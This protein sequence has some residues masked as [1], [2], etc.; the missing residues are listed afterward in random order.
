MRF[1]RGYE[2]AV[3][4]NFLIVADL[5]LGFELELERKGIYVPHADLLFKKLRFLI[6]I[7]KPNGLII[8]GD[9]KHM[10][11]MPLEREIKIVR[12]F[13]RKLTELVPRVVIVKGNHDGKIEE[14]CREIKNLEIVEELRF[15]GITLLHGHKK[16]ERFTTLLMGHV[17]PLVFSF[18][19]YEKA[20]IIA[21]SGK[22][23]IVVI[24]A[25][26]DLVGSPVSMNRKGLKDSSPVFR[27]IGIDKLALYSLEGEYL[28]ELD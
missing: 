20:W 12:G 27:T 22:R 7:T 1:V 4:K 21:S 25:L 28:G 14:I 26:S 17:H 18:G 11:R 5:H 13:L 9:V 6:E 10:V 16:P 19:E 3:V 2:A 24:P 15:G 23:R 8:L